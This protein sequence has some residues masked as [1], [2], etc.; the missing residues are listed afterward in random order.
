MQRAINALIDA[1]RSRFATN[2]HSSPVA[3]VSTVAE[4]TESQ[5]ATKAHDTPEP[6]EMS[7]YKEFILSSPLARASTSA[8]SDKLATI[9]GNE[10]VQGAAGACAAKHQR[11]VEMAG[12]MSQIH[13]AIE[14]VTH[15][16]A[17]LTPAAVVEAL[18]RRSEDIENALADIRE[19]HAVHQAAGLK[20]MARH[21]PLRDA[22]SKLFNQ[23]VMERDHLIREDESAA[24]AASMGLPTRYS[25][26]IRAGLSPAQIEA[27]EPT[28]L[29]PE[30]LIKRRR[31]RLADIAPQIQKL[32]AFA[33]STTFDASAIAG[34]DP[35]IDAAISARD[36][37]LPTEVA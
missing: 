30:I 24:R 12:F 10:S 37:A 17:D 35:A 32:R 34:I 28:A 33:T 29:A 14:A 21:K 2:E 36:C 23:L 27:T 15:D 16:G 1:A 5:A 8:V 7:I 9:Y 20:R 26:L 22:V 3:P 6:L 31:A 19:D 13:A 11:F 4:S 18:R 25:T